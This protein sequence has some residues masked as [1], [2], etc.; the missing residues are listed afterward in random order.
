MRRFS[1]VAAVL[2]VFGVLARTVWLKSSAVACAYEI[3]RLRD[4]AAEIDNHV[5][6]LEAEAAKRMTARKLLEAAEASGVERLHDEGEGVMRISVI[7]EPA[8][9]SRSS[10]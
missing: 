5:E 10:D 6:V 4:L 9:W 2:I 3:R 7:P 8:S 1:Y